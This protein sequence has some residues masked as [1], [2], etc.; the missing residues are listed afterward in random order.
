[1][2]RANN[3]IEVFSMLL[4]ALIAIRKNPSVSCWSTGGMANHQQPF[5]IP[6]ATHS[7]C[8]S[9]LVGYCEALIAGR[10]TGILRGTVGEKTMLRQ[11]VLP[12]CGER[13]G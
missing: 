1:M 12:S 2:Q 11:L 4:E 5:L 3:L 6:F 7:T 10:S 8:E 13:A 9:E